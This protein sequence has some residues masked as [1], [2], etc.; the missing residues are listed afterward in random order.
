MDE[1]EG[2]LIG[3]AGEQLKTLGTMQADCWFNEAHA[4]TFE[5][6]QAMFDLLNHLQRLY[7]AAGK[8]AESLGVDIEEQVKASSGVTSIAILALFA[9]LAPSHIVASISGTH[10]SNYALTFVVSKE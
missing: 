3:S 8:A 7:L 9:K 10:F 5:Q 4:Y 6:R 2:V 1:A